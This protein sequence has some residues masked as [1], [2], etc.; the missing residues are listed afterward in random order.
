MVVCIFTL[1]VALEIFSDLFC[2][3]FFLF[4]YF[5]RTHDLKKIISEPEAQQAICSPQMLLFNYEKNK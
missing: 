3:W 5:H 1:V 4:V 2:V